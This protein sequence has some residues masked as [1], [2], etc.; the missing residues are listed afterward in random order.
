MKSEIQTEITFVGKCV[1]VGLI[2]WPPSNKRPRGTFEK[3]I[4][5]DM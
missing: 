5:P 3:K 2:L 4:S 1:E